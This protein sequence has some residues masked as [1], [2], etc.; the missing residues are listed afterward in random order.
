[1]LKI[2]QRTIAQLKKKYKKVLH[3]GSKIFRSKRGL[4]E[5]VYT[6]LYKS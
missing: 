2:A 3:L 4:A 5:D 1:M 6:V